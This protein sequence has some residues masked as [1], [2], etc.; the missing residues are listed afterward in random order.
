VL[1]RTTGPSVSSIWAA[2]GTRSSISTKVAMI[3]SFANTALSQ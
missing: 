3:V 1:T 2:K